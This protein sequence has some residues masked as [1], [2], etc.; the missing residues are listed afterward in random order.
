VPAAT[1]LSTAE[2]YAHADRLGE[3]RSAASLGQLREALGAVAGTGVSPLRYAKLLVNDLEPAAISLR[4]E[5]EGALAA[6]REAGAAKALMSGSGPTVF[7]LFESGAAAERAAGEIGG[8]A[9]PIE[10]LRQNAGL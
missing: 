5:I 1:G 4:P 3:L 7:G 6:L 9:L 2:V 10:P 8:G